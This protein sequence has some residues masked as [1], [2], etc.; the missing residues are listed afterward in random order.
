MQGDDSAE[1][2]MS[3]G[4]QTDL[5]RVDNLIFHNELLQ[6]KKKIIDLEDRLSMSCATFAN[7]SVLQESSLARNLFNSTCTLVYQMLN[8][9]VQSLSL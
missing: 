5:T 7:D 8:S 4:V 6:S 1:D 3:V 2:T 9:Y